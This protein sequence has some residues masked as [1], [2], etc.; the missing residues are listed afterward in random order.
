MKETSKARRFR[1][2]DIN[3]GEFLPRLVWYSHPFVRIK[4]Y[5]PEVGN[6]PEQKILG[7]GSN[8][9]LRVLLQ[10]LGELGWDLDGMVGIGP[11]IERGHL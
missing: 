3:T 11:G 8:G 1:S 6:T 2:G 4:T 7:L 10:N 5:V 9:R